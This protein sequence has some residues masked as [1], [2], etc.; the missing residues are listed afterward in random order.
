[1]TAA[2]HPWTFFH[3][4]CGKPALNARSIPRT[5]EEAAAMPSLDGTCPWCAATLGP[6]DHAAM[7]VEGNWRRRETEAPATL[8]PPLGSMGEEAAPADSWCDGTVGCCQFIHCNTMRPDGM[9][10]AGRSTWL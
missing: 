4:A 7:T 2:T 6:I 3:T 9:K 5:A 10:C 8:L 1:M